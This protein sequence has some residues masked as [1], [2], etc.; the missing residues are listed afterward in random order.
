MNRDIHHLTLVVDRAPQVHA[1]PGDLHQ[2]P[3]TGR[4]PPRRRK[5]DT[6]RAELVDAA[7]NGLA[8]DR[9]AVLHHLH[10]D[11]DRDMAGR[12]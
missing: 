1:A 10:F 7:T 4:G 3:S 8:A 6:M 2:V 12:S 5:L 11:K 9:N